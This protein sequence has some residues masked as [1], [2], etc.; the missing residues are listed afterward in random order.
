MKLAQRETGA[1]FNPRWRSQVM[2][3]CDIIHAFDTRNQPRVEH[4]RASGCPNAPS[5]YNELYK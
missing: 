5:F 4:H 2:Y 1:S 3:T